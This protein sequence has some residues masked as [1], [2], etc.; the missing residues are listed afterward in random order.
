[1][2]KI[3]ISFLLPVFIYSCNTKEA[4]LP[5]LGR[6]TLDESGKE[7][8]HEIPDF[9]FTN[10]YNETV[11]NADFDEKVYVADFFFTSCPTICPIMKSQML[12]INEHFKGNENFKILSHTIDPYHDSVQVLHDY[13]EALGIQG[14]QWQFVTGDQDKIYEMGEKAYMVPAAEDT[15]SAEESGGYIHSGAFILVDQKRHIRGVYDGTLEEEVNQ[16]IRDI[17]LLIE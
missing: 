15:I 11:T 16:L 2:N 10:Q 6:A 9:S 3:V 1:M 12:R 5:I 14:E 17:E 13:A 7:I 8:P 4:S